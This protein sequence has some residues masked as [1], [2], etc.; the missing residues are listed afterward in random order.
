MAHTIASQRYAE[1][2]KPAEWAE[3]GLERRLLLLFA[4]QCQGTFNPICAFFGG[5]VAQEI[6]KA[7]TGK[8]TPVN[9]LFYYNAVEVL[10]NFDPASNLTNFDQF[11]AQLDIAITGHRSDGLKLCVGGALCERLARTRLF[12]VGAGAIG[13]ELLKNLA[14]LGV[15][16][17]KAKDGDESTAG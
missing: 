2:L 10:P 5:F 12:M 14:M 15:G 11:V 4:F 17:A 6:V 9:Q 3:D 13:C 8:F 16:S 1:D 7:I